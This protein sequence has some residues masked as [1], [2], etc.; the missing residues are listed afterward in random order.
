MNPPNYKPVYMTNEILTD[1]VTNPTSGTTTVVAFNENPQYCLS[2]ESAKELFDILVAAYPM[3]RM[4]LE[5]RPPWPMGMGS[6][7]KFN[8]D[9]PWIT[10]TNRGGGKDGIDQVYAFNA[11]GFADYWAS[12][13]MA[14][15][16]LYRDPGVAWRNAVQDISVGLSYLG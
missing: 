12:A 15:L 3:Y 11:G 5:M 13:S 9:V 1:P 7:S 6:P 14:A 10:I 16:G 2:K 8:L 4:T